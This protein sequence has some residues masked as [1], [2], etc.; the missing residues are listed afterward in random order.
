MTADQRN[1]YR[2]QHAFC[3]HMA[4]LDRSTH[5]LQIQWGITPDLSRAAFWLARARTHRL[6]LQGA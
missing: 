4:R 6:T 5:A 3:L 1:H 2:Q